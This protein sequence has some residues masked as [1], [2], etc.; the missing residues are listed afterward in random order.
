MS[1]L[2]DSVLLHSPVDSP[3]FK[4]PSP[5]LLDPR[6]SLNSCIFVDP[7]EEELEGLLYAAR[8]GDIQTILALLESYY[9]GSQLNLN[10]TRYNSP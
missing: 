3:A 4:S 9:S 8:H 5:D 2:E 7:K 1:D 6:S 10:A